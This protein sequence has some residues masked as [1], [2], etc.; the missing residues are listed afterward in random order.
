MISCETPCLALKERKE[1]LEGKRGR[2]VRRGKKGQRWESKQNSCSFFYSFHPCT[3]CLSP[4]L[5]LWTRSDCPPLVPGSLR[6][7]PTLQPCFQTRSLMRSTRPRRLT[8]KALGNT[9]THTYWEA[10]KRAQMHAQRWAGTGSVSQT[11]TVH[12]WTRKQT[13]KHKSRWVHLVAGTLTHRLASYQKHSKPQ[14]NTN[15]RPAGTLWHSNSLSHQT[16]NCTLRNKPRTKSIFSLFRSYSVFIY[17]CVTMGLTSLLLWPRTH[18]SRN[19]MN[20]NNI[21]GFIQE[22]TKQAN[23]YVGQSVSLKLDDLS[24]NIMQTC[25]T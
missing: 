25:F 9:H 22:L 8:P 5:Q 19:G 13:D 16:C 17:P 24:Q 6:W 11:Y 21:A 7:R 3:I 23:R 12:I 15:T 20:E 14:T 1:G 4:S 2:V 18:Y 10:G